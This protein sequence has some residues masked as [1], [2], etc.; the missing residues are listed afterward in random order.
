MRDAGVNA[1]LPKRV[2]VTGQNGYIGSILVPALIEAGCEVSGLDTGYFHQCT[3]LPDAT[4]APSLRK[5]VRDVDVEDL[6]GLDAIVHLAALSNDP[7]GNLNPRWTEAINVRASIRLAEL[8]KAAGVTRFLFSSSCIMYG[9]SEAN[10]V[11]EESPLDPRTAYARSKVDSERAIAQLAGDGFSPTF[12]RNGTIYGLSPR[13][14][15]DTVFNDMMGLAAATGRV[16]VYSDGKPWRPVVHVRDVARAFMTV[17]QA[18]LADV[19]NQAFNIGAGHLNHQVIELA[20]IVVKTVRDC[21]LEVLAQPGADQRTYRTDFSKFARTFPEFEFRWS[22]RDG[23]Q[24]LYEAFRAIRLTHD[25]YVDKRF[26]RL[27]WLRHLLDVGSLDDSLRWT[28]GGVA[29]GH[30]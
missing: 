21:T 14:R 25:T 23:A 13:M 20:D 15:F 29:R 2:L 28:D 7:I 6:R 9:M 17:L 8:A 22:A 18:P 24:E 19:H 12:L 10:V 3:L 1:R 26:T 30:D 27:K 5:D 4:Q 11:T 16:V